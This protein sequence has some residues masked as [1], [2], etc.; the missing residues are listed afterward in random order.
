ME[1][2]PQYGT[3]PLVALCEYVERQKL[4]QEFH[5]KLNSIT[6]RNMMTPKRAKINEQFTILPVNNEIDWL[7]MGDYE[8]EILSAFKVERDLFE[9]K[10]RML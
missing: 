10:L 9:L 6:C 8:N 1:S 5:K 3:S 2:K 4:S 7:P